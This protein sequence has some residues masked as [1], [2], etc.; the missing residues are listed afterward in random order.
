M[1]SV[2]FSKLELAFYAEVTEAIET[3]ADGAIKNILKS[4]NST[5]E[6]LDEKEKEIYDLFAELK[7]SNE[8]LLSLKKIIEKA[9]VGVVHSLFATIDGDT[10]LS[11][12]GKALEVVDAK[13]GVPITQGALHE[14]F[15]FNLPDELA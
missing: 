6:F 2:N 7:L 9:S 5:Y 13:T 15:I 10:A 3:F 14:N 11:N 8:T 12:D 4:E 1:C